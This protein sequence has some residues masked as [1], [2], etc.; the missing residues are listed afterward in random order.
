MY[1]PLWSQVLSNVADILNTP[2]L[3]QMVA[4]LCLSLDVDS[5]FYLQTWGVYGP[6]GWWLCLSSSHA[7]PPGLS[8]TCGVCLLI[9]LWPLE[10]VCIP[11]SCW[12]AFSS[13]LRGE[14]CSDLL[15]SV[16][17]LEPSS[18]LPV[19]TQQFPLISIPYAPLENCLSFRNLHLFQPQ[20]FQG[21]ISN[22]TVSPVLAS[23]FCH[24][25]KRLHAWCF[26]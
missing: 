20:S 22:L 15:A 1:L 2:L 10:L 8:L 26:K 17:L 13:A 25:L 12:S 7:S 11:D 24:L 23:L 5:G 18:G 16:S 9:C 3:L 4:Q 14:L 19:C 21:E 6:T